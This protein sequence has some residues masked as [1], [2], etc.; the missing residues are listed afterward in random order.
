MCRL[1]AVV[2]LFAVLSLAQ[3][4]KPFTADVMMKLA[5]VSDHQLSSDG[6][7]VVFTVQ[8][9]DVEANT[10]PRQIWTVPLAGGAPVQLTTEGNNFR[11]RWSPDSKRLAFISTRGGAQ[12]VWTMDPDGKNQ[13]PLTTIATEADGVTWTGD[14]KQLIF[15]SEVYPD[16]TGEACNAKSLEADKNSKV[17]A[18]IYT[19]LLY[20][21]WDQWQGPRR[22]HLFAVSAEGGAPRDLTPGPNDV[23]PFSLGGNDDYAASYDGN[24]VAFAMNADSSPAT[25]TNADLYVVP[26]GGG[27]VRRITDNLGADNSPVYSPDGR[28]LAYRSQARAGFESDRWR[29]M[30][31]DRSTG[32]GNALT[33]GLDRNVGSITFSPDSKRIFFSVEDRGR[34]AIHMVP[35]TGGASKPVVTGS[36]HIEEAQ[37]TPD[38]KTMIYAE[39]SGSRPMEIYKA[40]S[41]G[42]SPQPLTRFNDDILALYQL[43]PLEEFWV[44]GAERAQVHSF[45]VKPPNF[46]KDERYPV[47]FLI[48]GGPQGAWGESWSYRWNPQVFAAAGFVV[49]MP[50]PRGST[51]YGQ[52]FTD[53]VSGDWGGKVYD[54]I[55][56]VVDHVT[57]ESWADPNRFA[58]AGGSYGGYMMNWMQGHTQ[59]FR[60]MVCHAG[61]YD[62][63]SMGGE[64]EELWFAKWEFGGMPWETPEVH[65]RWSPS[66]FVREFKTPTLVIHGELDFR[67]PYGQGL[68]LFTALQTQ[69]VPS[70]L[71]LYPDEGH[72]I[73]KPQNSMLWYK[74]FIDWVTEWTARKPASAL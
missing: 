38:G 12:Q 60:A 9:I 41:G 15:I 4:K 18:R 20:R 40:V 50:N 64:T 34:S 21:H 11:A 54:D 17:K 28:W 67:V 30:L 55:M 49:V 29:L 63:K 68:Q 36:S 57:K 6:K 10:K 61:V 66:N 27:E 26:A 35:I 33:E 37:F 62:L 31:L 8:R 56:A 5:R 22:K 44:E 65:E 39:V 14:G 52:R 47:L 23:P 2:G 74:S 25:S 45:V 3:S 58:A 51:G 71:L 72:W 7:A 19:S 43:T 1:A 24:E 59:R 48:H 69:K 46:R 53:E 42:G 70:K 73:G 32:R 13:K 16:C